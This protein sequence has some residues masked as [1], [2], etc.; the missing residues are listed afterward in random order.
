M[1]VEEAKSLLGRCRLRQG[2][3]QD[4]EV[5]EALVLAE[6]TPELKKWFAEQ[7]AFD[8]QMA[9]DVQSIAVPGDLRGKLLALDTVQPR[10]RF[11]SLR[12]ALAM[13]A[14]VAVLGIIAA[15]W[16]RSKPLEFASLRQHIL[17]ASWGQQPHLAFKT[18][19]WNEV[20]AWLEG[21]NVQ[22]ELK[23]P[24]ALQ[25]YRL[26]G[27]TLVQWH[28]HSVPVLCLS[29]GHRHMHLCVVDHAEL[30]DV[31]GADMPE[32]GKFGPMATASW[33]KADKAYV[34]TGFN[35]LSFFKTF[36]KSGRWVMSG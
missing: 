27:C 3:S 8:A 22:A 36:R 20:R 23:V 31:P 17:E 14:A 29:D 4:P 26:H 28:G 15:I 7:Q 32:F 33:S 30:A 6:R 18:K 2:D 24:L 1:N 25:E 13:A 16:W 19:D 12:P 35:T 21:R 5:A 9:E 11:R 10:S 34:L